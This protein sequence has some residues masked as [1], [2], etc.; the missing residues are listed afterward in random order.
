MLAGARVG[1][2]HHHLALRCDGCA[3]RK[4]LAVLGDG[5]LGEWQH[6]VQ[7]AVEIILGLW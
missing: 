5:L 6:E 2:Q 4:H 1:T 3:E 7:Q